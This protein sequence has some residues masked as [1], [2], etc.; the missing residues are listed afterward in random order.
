MNRTLSRFLVF[1]ACALAA[2]WLARAASAPNVAVEIS[3]PNPTAGQAVRLWDAG[4]E[5]VSGWFWDFGDGQ[6]SQA[7][8][9]SHAWDEAGEYTVR[10]L[11]EGASAEMP[12][13][14]S[15]PGTL[16]LNVAHPFELT[17]ESYDRVTG[18]PF[19]ARAFAHSDGFG[20]F[21][22]PGLTGNLENPEVTV[23]VLEA[24]HDG[25]YWF[26][27]SGMTTLD[28]TLTIREVST[29]RVAI[30]RK[31]GTAPCGGWDTRSFAFVPTPTPA[32]PTYTPTKTATPGSGVPTR[33]PQNTRTRTP[34]ATA[35][36]TPTITAT[37]TITPTPTPAPPPLISLRAIQWQWDFFSTDLGIVG[38]SQITL[39]AGQTYQVLVYNGDAEDVTEVHSLSSI[40]G[41]GLQGGSIPQGESLPLQTITPMN[42]GTFTFNCTTFCGFN[43]DNMVG[44]VI[45]VP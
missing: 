9:P 41:I 1:P 42:P 13:V 12:V 3:P 11:A 25:H 29:G 37:P 16:R 32:A 8:A 34:T 43:H 22:F 36:L 26:F 38:G 44:V 17:L 5:A 14:V 20:W 7:A 40:S 39:Q 27:W 23:K 28:Y 2:A 35:T 15:A 45:V 10:L 6:S 33:T 19:E 18:E 30:H 4:A 31:E 24:K 21:S